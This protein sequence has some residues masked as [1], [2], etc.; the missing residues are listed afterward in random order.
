VGDLNGL[1]N[2]VELNGVTNTPSTSSQTLVPLPESEAFVLGSMVHWLSMD[3]TV[4]S[5]TQATTIAYYVDGVYQL[6]QNVAQAC[7]DSM[8]TFSFDIPV[9]LGLHK[10][11][12]LYCSSNTGYA[13]SS[14]SRRRTFGGSSK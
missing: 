5:N 11:H 1:R 10:C 14:Y 13:A 6:K 3:Y 7:F 8:T 4:I 2:V 12:I 9:P